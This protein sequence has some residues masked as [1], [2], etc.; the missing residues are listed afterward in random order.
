MY[1]L[2]KLHV[3]IENT[4]AHLIECSGHIIEPTVYPRRSG[5]GY[6]VLSAKHS[7][8]LTLIFDIL[9]NDG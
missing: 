8:V 5:R 9:T 4:R 7:G 1:I 3:R 2:P 6:T